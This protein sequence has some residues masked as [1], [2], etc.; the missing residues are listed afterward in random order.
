MRDFVEWLQGELS[1]L[2]EKLNFKPTYY[3]VHAYYS[4]SNTR[5]YRFPEEYLAIRHG[6]YLTHKRIGHDIFQVTVDKDI[7]IYRRIWK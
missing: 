4:D 5:V 2:D 1:I 6:D 7:K 3:E